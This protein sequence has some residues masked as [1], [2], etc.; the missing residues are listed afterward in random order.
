MLIE[1]RIKFFSFPLRAWGMFALLIYCLIPFETDPAD[2]S[3]AIRMIVAA[4]LTFIAASKINYSQVNVLGV[5]IAAFTCFIV[6]VIVSAFV[7]FSFRFFVI[8]SALFF[9]ALSAAAV[10]TNADYRYDFILALRLLIY[11]SVGLL[12][13]QIVWWQLGGGIIQFHDL[14]FP[15]SAGRTEEHDLFVRLGGMYIEPGTHAHWLFMIYLVYLFASRMTIDKTALFVGASLISTVSVWGVFAGFLLVVAY[16]MLHISGRNYFFAIIASILGLLAAYLLMDSSLYH[17]VEGK[18]LFE[19]ESGTSKI[20]AYHEFNLLLTNILFVGDGFDPG[21]CESCLSP[22]DAGLFISIS[23]VFGLLF[24]CIIFVAMLFGSYA[25][26][27]VILL[28]LT[29]LVFA[30]K[31]FYWDYV[32]WLAFFLLIPIGK[33]LNR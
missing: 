17:F 24:T 7:S 29:A 4:V 8:I 23:V 30:T 31:L 25:Q 15:F 27:G 10:R 26:G 20:D 21:F 11:I 2:I 12:F 33:R 32:F 28:I 1:S 13:A 22:Q 3:I 19:S 5:Y 6:F 9:A 14:V 18:L 16:I